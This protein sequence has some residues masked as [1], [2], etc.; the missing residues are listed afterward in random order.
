VGTGFPQKMRQNQK[1]RAI[2][3]SIESEI[4]LGIPAPS[5]SMKIAGAVPEQEAGGERTHEACDL[6]QS[7]W[8]QSHEKCPLLRV[9][10]IELSEIGN[11]KRFESGCL[12][13][14][15]I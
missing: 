6:Q 10:A 3:D 14:T 15:G 13:D 8:R 1:P 12:Q 2:S 11:S 7:D 5:R 9:V 4:A